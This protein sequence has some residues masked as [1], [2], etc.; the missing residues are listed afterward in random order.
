ME[1]TLFVVLAQR[2]AAAPALDYSHRQKLMQAKLL[3]QFKTRAGMVLWDIE[4]ILVV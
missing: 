2:A 3:V 4:G 1:A